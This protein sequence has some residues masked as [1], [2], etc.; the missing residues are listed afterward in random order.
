[1]QFVSFEVKL[2]HIEKVKVL[3]WCLQSDGYG[4]IE[5]LAKEFTCIGSSAENPSFLTSLI[6]K[7]IFRFTFI[8]SSLCQR[9][10]AVL[11]SCSF[12]DVFPA[13]ISPN[14]VQL[15][16]KTEESKFHFIEERCNTS[17]NYILHLLLFK[18]KPNDFIWCSENSEDNSRQDIPK[19]KWPLPPGKE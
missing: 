17:R 1:M 12:V 11:D 14:L 3:K 6:I 5:D 19:W 18:Q 10:T 13:Y 8:I 15:H 7:I 4:R 16:Q 2:L 9:D